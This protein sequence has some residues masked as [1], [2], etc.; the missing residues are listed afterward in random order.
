MKQSDLYVLL[1]TPLFLIALSCASLFGTISLESFD[2]EMEAQVLVHAQLKSR[3]A[4]IETK[5]KN[6]EVAIKKEVAR[7]IYSNSRSILNA[8]QGLF[9]QFGDF[10]SEIGFWAKN[11]NYYVIFFSILNAFFVIRISRSSKRKALEV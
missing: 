9:R 10:S 8:Q 7:E 4:D 5:I 6:D 3:L 2:E 11:Q 1:S